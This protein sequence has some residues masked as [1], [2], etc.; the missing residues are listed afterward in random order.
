MMTEHRDT[1]ATGHRGSDEGTYEPADT[2]PA[3]DNA[4]LGRELR[5]LRKARGHTLATLAELSGKSIGYLSQIERGKAKPSLKTLQIIGR[6]L[7]VRVGW[8]FREGEPGPGKR[9]VVRADA[10]RRLTYTSLWTDDYLQEVNTLISPDLDR[11]VAMGL[12]S[13]EAG[14]SSGDDDY[15]LESEVSCYI[16]SGALTLHIDG[17]VHRLEPGDAYFVP[18]GVLHHYCNDG[19]EKVTWL[20]AIAPPKF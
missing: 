18:E 12:T 11:K 9:Y 16:L 2:S 15:A 4:D 8:F 5:E 7:G 1:P 17:E 20:W 19:P 14:A 6:I 13:L 10:H 3:S